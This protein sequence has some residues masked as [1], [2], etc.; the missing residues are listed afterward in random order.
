[1]RLYEMMLFWKDSNTAYL[2][3]SSQ[4]DPTFAE[5]CSVVD[6]RLMRQVDEMQ[7]RLR[8]AKV[9]RSAGKIW[10]EE[11]FCFHPAGGFKFKYISF[12]VSLIYTCIYI[13][14]YIDMYEP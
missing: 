8:M 4:L 9:R 14:I 12:S 6:S 3:K 10:E 2:N 11:P 7:D 13:Y 1:M 5:F